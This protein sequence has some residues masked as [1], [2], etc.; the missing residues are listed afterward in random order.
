MT[1]FY[2]VHRFFVKASDIHG[3]SV[4]LGPD[5]CHQI[6]DVLR[7]RPGDQIII[8]DNT[9]YESEVR[10]ERLERV[11]AEGT[12]ITT[13]LVDAEPSVSLTLYQAIVPRAKFELVLQ[14]CT[15]V[16]V[17]RFVPWLADRS[18]NK[19]PLSYDRLAR[20]QKILT[21]AAE[22]SGR[23]LIPVLE[24]CRCPEDFLAKRATNTLR[25][26]AVTGQANP[27]DVVLSG[28]SLK[29]VELCIGPEGGLSP[30]EVQMA[31]AGGWLPFSMGRRILRTE[32]AAV[33]ASA[34]ILFCL[35]EMRY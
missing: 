5:L 13:R 29:H 30:R 7:L 11:F 2:L 24:T 27:L 3:R 12:I 15:E 25:L 1:G 16:G 9:G 32:T 22:Q 26:M 34:I 33:V 8:L 14:K 19:G 23:G 6:R 10:L 35:H 17:K 18:V 31:Q 20:W 28:T 4:R 21:E